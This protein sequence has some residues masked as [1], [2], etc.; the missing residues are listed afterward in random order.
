MH[1]LI[2]QIATYLRAIW[3]HRW[4]GLGAAWLVAVIG[5]VVVMKMPDKYE[6]SARIYVDT[7]SIL[8]PL[9]SGLAVQPNVEQ[10][11]TMLSR[12]LISRPNVEKLIRMADLDLNVKSKADQ[13]ALTDGL[14]KELK[15]QGTSNDNLYTLNY[16]A[17]D[18]E[19]AKKVVQA[20]VSIF[21]ESSLGDNRKDTESARQFID[22][23]I[24]EYEKK[25]EDA[26]GRLKD[27][28]LRN[29]DFEMGEGQGTLGQLGTI[30]SLRDQARLELR[31]AENS[32]DALKRQIVGEEPIFL[33]E[34]DSSQ[35]VP[36][37]DGRIASLKQNLDAMLQRYTE[38]HPD[39]VGTRRVIKDL[40]EQKK[41]ELAAR[42]KLA[43]AHP[44][45]SLNANPV[46]QQL[47][48]ALA[49]AES[50]VASLRARAGEYEARF[51]RLQGSMRN[52]PEVEKEYAQLNRDYD[53]LKNSYQSLVSRREAAAM[54][55][56]L[57]ERGARVDFK[58]IDP[59]RTSPKPVAPNRLLLLAISLLATLAAGVA[60]AFA[61]SQ[62]R[63]V[64]FNG[65]TVREVFDLPIL[66]TI[67]MVP[68]A[69]RTLQEKRDLRRF[70]AVFS[71]LVAAY[72]VGFAGL[73][74]LAQRVV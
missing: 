12:T 14:M 52:Q 29:L 48:V 42:R 36:E 6:A 44:M 70:L 37:I 51:A 11:I 16:R 34:A 9:M 38:D 63:P 72:V 33:P 40:E 15:I 69:K 22:D 66:G 64:F 54:S 71:G 61:A 68:N 31:E 74:I 46:L 30:S 3:R 41:Q 39:V 10:S 45:S 47:R 50:R 17:T 20:M 27:F 23:Q 5:A 43:A 59:P 35:S 67:T 56:N 65:R 13:E 32:R 21:V 73:L 7:Q 28:K 24:K 53:I 1:D 26:E 2:L 19:S 58:L 62:L 55:G 4:L 25:L 8:K 18:P 57:E 49:E 60:V